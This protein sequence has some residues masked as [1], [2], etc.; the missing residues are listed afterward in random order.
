MAKQLGEI[1]VTGTIEGL[2][3]YKMYGDYFV[4]MKSS[5]TARRFWKDRAF[6]GSRR[7]CGL[8]AKASPLA[9][10]FYKNY[11]K[12]KKRKGLFNE[13]TGRVKLW[14]KEGKTEEEALLLLQEN[15]PVKQKETKEKNKNRKV[16]KAI[17]VARK[18][19]L[20]TVCLDKN[21]ILDERVMK[22]KKL[23]FLKE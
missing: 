10:F 11:P 7:S 4:R 2:S 6:E 8:L 12:E 23:R 15:Y 19:K 9:S 5:L 14:L 20:F 3:F 21:I 18:E 22:R 17:V 1:K 13:M 16:K